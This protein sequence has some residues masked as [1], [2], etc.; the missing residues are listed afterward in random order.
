MLAHLCFN[1]TL[2]DLID[3]EHNLLACVIVDS[4]ASGWFIKNQHAL[5]VYMVVLRVY[6]LVGNLIDRV[7]NLRACVIVDSMAS[8]WFITYRCGVQRAVGVW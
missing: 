6:M 2:A 7:H 4:V 1:T 8:G 3:R 5:L